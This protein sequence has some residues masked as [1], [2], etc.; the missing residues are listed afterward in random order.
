[1]N[2]QNENEKEEAPLVRRNFL[3]AGLAV[4][5]AAAAF[6]SGLHVGTGSFQN[7]SMEAGL[8]SFLSE[9]KTSQEIDLKEFWDVWELLE[10]K[11]VSA[12][13]TES[14]TI[15][16]RIEGAINGL[17][18][19]YGDPYTVFLPPSDASMFEEDISGNFGGV[20]ME[21]GLRDG[22][23]T[24]IAP[25]PNTPAAKAGIVAKD[26]ITEIDGK[27]TE[28]LGIDDAVRLIRGEVG[29]TVT[30]KIYREG[31]LE[32]LTIPVV[33]DEISIPTVDTKKVGEVFVIS[34]YSFN[35][36]S[37]SKMEAA[38]QEYAKS[39]ASKLIVDLRGNPG[40]FLQS[41][42]SIASYFVPAGKTVVRENFGE[43]LPEEVYRSQGKTLGE[44]MP[45]EMLVLVDG[46]SAS[47][48][49]ILAGALQEHG[50]AK[51]LGEQTFGKGS[52]QEL[53]SLKDGSSLKVTVARWFTPNG[54]SISE[55]GLTPDIVVDRTPQQVIDGTDPQLDAAVAWLNG[56]KTVGSTTAKSAT[57]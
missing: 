3:G 26:V 12:S 46:G 57:P 44:F 40:G 32:L 30:L 43:G 1:M 45:E 21:V 6:F 28:G 36:I 11:Y 27:S 56:D 9:P 13:S 4:L 31:E 29:T 8:F 39:G 35:A 37:E 18:R 49:E 34:L 15:E 14:I 22:L 5:L 38:L 19:S 41:A 10:E 54:V 51:L 20:G 33:R 17:V 25:L 24:V 23:V 53:V 55:G 16:E 7:S 2:D 50:I 52:V 48:S 42:V 47:A